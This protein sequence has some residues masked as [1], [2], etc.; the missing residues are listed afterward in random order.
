MQNVILIVHLILAICLI[1]AVLLQR[2]EGGALG[3]GG[4]GGGGISSRGTTSPLAKLTWALATAFIA[5]SITL[6]ILA[7]NDPAGRSV[8]DELGSPPEDGIILP[9]LP[10][11]AEDAPADGAGEQGGVTLPDLPPAAEDGGGDGERAPVA[12][13]TAD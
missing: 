5:T 8:I 10:P 13:P 6:A 12:P 2:S 9:D 1:A 11:A 4:G 3:I 7:G